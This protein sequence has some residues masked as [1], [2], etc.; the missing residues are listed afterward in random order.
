[1]RDQIDDFS[2]WVGEDQSLVAGI[3]AAYFEGAHGVNQGFNYYTVG[4]AD[5]SY[6]NNGLGA[7]FAAAASNSK[8]SSGSYQTWALTGQVNYMFIRDKLEAFARYDYINRT[9]S[10]ASDVNLATI[11]LIYYMAAHSAKFSFDIQYG[12]GHSV[13]FA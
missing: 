11:G 1:S 2:S 5:V 8:S 3:A 12:G 6:E 4:V 10:S 13:N 7:Y 9:D